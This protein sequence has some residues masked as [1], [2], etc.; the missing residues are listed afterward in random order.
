MEMPDL[1]SYRSYRDFLR[2]WFLARKACEPRFSHRVFA[3]KAGYTST[4]LVPLLVQGKRNLTERYL[5]GFVRA[6][7]LNLREATYFRALVEFTHAT[8]DGEKRR[9]EQV[10]QGLC[11]QGPRRLEAARSRFY[12]SWIHVALHQALTC[13][14]VD[15]D[16][17]SVRD[18][19]TPSPSL[20]ELRRGLST[21]KELKLIAKD[22]RGFW[23]P[24]DSNLLG[25]ARTGPWV[26]RGFREQMIDLGKTAHERVDASRRLAMS[27]TLAVSSEAAQRIRERFLQFRREVVEIAL[28]DALPA[29]EIT[30]VN[31]Q[32]F[33][34]SGALS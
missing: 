32:L 10:L 1:E 26:I 4:A 23:K 11:L 27:E 14:E 8:S 19:L 30:Q 18:F 9:L 17:A 12:E 22:A 28:N 13:L 21:L 15:A 34:L 31:L 24:T 29:Q 7:G 20:E 33:P 5:D 3:R 25:D 2:D 16:L 6:L